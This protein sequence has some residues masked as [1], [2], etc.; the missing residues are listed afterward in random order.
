MRP[1]APEIVVGIDRCA[2]L[3]SEQIEHPAQIALRS[4]DDL[5]VDLG[6]FRTQVQLLKQCLPF[7]AQARG[8]FFDQAVKLLPP[9]ARIAVQAM[10]LQLAVAL[11]AV[12][13]HR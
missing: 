10:L 13:L 11:P 7:I 2:L 12:A 4:R 9:V 8:T 6:H 1:A 5:T 3:T